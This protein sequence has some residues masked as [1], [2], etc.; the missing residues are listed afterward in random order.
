MNLRK[1]RKKGYC[2]AKG[3]FREVTG[4][5][6]CN[7]CRSRSAKLADPVKYAYKNLKFNARR[8]GILFTITLDQFREFCHRVQ[9]IGFKGRKS[10]SYTIDRIH[11]DLGYHIDNI[12]ILTLSDN[13][14]KYLRFDRE[15]NK[16]YWATNIAT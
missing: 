11:N 5:K 4:R 12:Q 3:C 15:R 6:L 2:Q 14:K 9:Y 10:E 16:Y 1:H 13:V 7:T 8:R